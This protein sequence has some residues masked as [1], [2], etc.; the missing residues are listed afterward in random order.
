[1]G[2]GGKQVSCRQRGWCEHEQLLVLV[3]AWKSLTCG[4]HRSSTSLFWGTSL[5]R[6]E[7]QVAA[8]CPRP[9]RS[10]APTC[11]FGQIPSQGPMW[12]LHEPPH[13]IQH[14]PP[15]LQ[16]SGKQYKWAAESAE[17]TVECP[18]PATAGLGITS[19]PYE[20]PLRC[21]LPCVQEHGR[22]FRHF[23]LR[24]LAQ[25]PGEAWHHRQ[26]QQQLLR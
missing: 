22:V 3:F 1:M 14:H 23:C 6:P 4:V 7:T 19:Q 21:P 26:R 13:V 18:G 12:T 2:R 5:H 15:T 25:P 9:S 11:N 10:P 20:T 8:P 16:R 24:D 17:A